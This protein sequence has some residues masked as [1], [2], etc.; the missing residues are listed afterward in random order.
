MKYKVIFSFLLSL[1]LIGCGG[2]GENGSDPFGGGDD[3]GTSSATGITVSTFAEDCS[4]PQASFTAGETVCVEAELVGSSAAITNQVITFSNGL[5]TLSVTTRLTNSNGIA[6]VNITSTESDIGAN[7][8]TATFDTLSADANYEFLSTVT[9]SGSASLDV[10][11]SRNGTPV[12]SF[13]T[14]QQVTVQAQLLDAQQQGIANQI[15]TFSTV[16]G[17]LTPTTALT[18]DLG[19]AQTSL[20]ATD[21]DIGAT[22]L[23]AQVD[24]D[25]ATIV[26]AVNYQILPVDT[27]TD[28]SVQLGQ[29]EDGAFVANVLGVSGLDSDEDVTISAGGTLGLS[30]VLVD[31]LGNRVTTPTQVT[32]TS[33]CVQ[34]GLATL[35]ETVTTINGEALS[36]FEDVSCAGSNGNTDQIV[37]SVVSNN[38]TLTVIRDIS[39][40]PEALGSINFVSATPENIVLFGTG[41]QNSSS[42]S[43]LTFQVVGA[44]GNPLAQQEVNF[45]LNTDVGNLTIAPTSGFTNSQGQVST[46]VTAGTVPTAVRVTARTTSEDGTTISTQSDLLAVNTGLPD[47]N[48]FSLS[49]SNLNAEGFNIDGTTSIITARLGDS[50]NNPVPDG[51]AVS[52]TT[53]GG[54]ITP[55]CTTQNGACSVTWTSSAPRTSDHR[56]TIL[57]TAIGHETLFDSNGNN[58][59]DVNDGAA[60]NDGFDSGIEVSLGSPTQPGFLDYSEAWRDDNENG[61]RDAAETF[62]D[63]NNNGAFDEADELFNGPQCDP[64][65][66]CGSSTTNVRRAIVLIES[67]SAAFIDVVDNATSTLFSNNGPATNPTISLDVGESLELTAQVSDTATQPLASGTTINIVSILGSAT[68][69]TSAT[70]IITNS[71]TITELDFSVVNNRSDLGTETMVDTITINVTS[72]SGV[73]TSLIFNVDLLPAP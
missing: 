39:L 73:V 13:T 43:T 51:T 53:E 11:L 17:T 67:S 5:G 6:Q 50:F 31:S 1:V 72:P 70:Q 12:S 15:V 10:F 62:L 59:F 3:N 24:L 65:A 68:G 58:Q 46:R 40:Q 23:T 30:V 34:S 64:A 9:A 60:I 19:I 28:E 35:D 61:V 38:Q 37:A 66:A 56:I 18:N 2:S 55:S 71:R 57:A 32:F 20:T 36:T 21:T 69:T 45:S 63:F 44:L 25:Q 48:S 33:N 27:V 54:T 47:Q 8:V 49:A 42:V 29:F 41:G 7:T 22:A 14:S 52:F 16:L 26:D 4:T